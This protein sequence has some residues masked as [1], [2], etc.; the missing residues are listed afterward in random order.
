MSADTDIR[1]LLDCV[2]AGTLRTATGN[3]T[4][5]RGQALLGKVEAIWLESL[6]NTMLLRALKDEYAKEIE[7]LRE[8]NEKLTARIQYLEIND[9]S[10]DRHGTV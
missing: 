2:S 4:T 9:W 10:R 8:T 1:L 7:A 6:N 5:K 3:M